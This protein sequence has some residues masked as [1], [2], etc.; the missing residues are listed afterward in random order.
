[1]RGLYL[2]TPDW[3]DTDKLVAVTAQAIEGG[4]TLLQYR[5]KTASEALRSEQ[6]SALLAL[7]RRKNIPLIIW[8]YVSA[9]MQTAFMLAVRMLLLRQSDQ[10]SAKKK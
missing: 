8:I 7:C 6:S 1:M 9:S 2:V 3:D 4:A 10:K 5:H